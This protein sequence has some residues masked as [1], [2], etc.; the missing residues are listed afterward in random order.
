[1]IFGYLDAGT[2]SLLLQL[3]V[4]GIGGLIVFMKYRWASL[5]TWFHRNE[6]T[7]S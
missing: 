2:G 4:G 6:K 3:I 5:K 7:E 1:M